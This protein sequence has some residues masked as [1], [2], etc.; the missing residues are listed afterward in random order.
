MKTK[1]IK[2]T[3]EQAKADRATLIK[4]LAYKSSVAP[5]TMRVAES[6]AARVAKFEGTTARQVLAECWI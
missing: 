2:L 4:M 6:I 1:T 5:F 3:A